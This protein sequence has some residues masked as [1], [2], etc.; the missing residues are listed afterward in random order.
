MGAEAK[1]EKVTRELSTS[2]IPADKRNV[3]LKIISDGI[4]SSE[5]STFARFLK[6]LPDNEIKDIEVK[7]RDF[8]TRTMVLLSLY[9]KKDNS[10]QKLLMV[11]HLMGRFDLETNI[12]NI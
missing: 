12:K 3:I 6:F 4:P 10:L 5:F 2:K 11:L 8:R 9:E 1:S 7:Y